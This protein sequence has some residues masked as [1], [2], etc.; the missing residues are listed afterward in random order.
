MLRFIFS[1]SVISLG[2]V[3]FCQEKEKGNTK[4]RRSF[5]P[6]ELKIGVNAI[7][8]GRSLI[9]SDFFMTHEFQ[10]TLSMYKTILVFDFGVEE[11]R[12][13]DTY[14]YTNKGSYFRI[15]ADW[16]FVK[17]HQTGNVLSLGLRYAE[18]RFDDDITYTT[19]Q[20]FGEQNYSFLNS[21]LLA[22]WA[23]LTVNLRGQVVSNLYMGFT[24]R[25][26]FSRKIN[27]ETILK[28]FDIP[29]F[30]KTKRQNST[31]FDYYIAWRIPL[32]KLE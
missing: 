10:G 20:G 27:R 13:G 8:S 26:Q 23:E 29:G 32:K 28:S 2:G 5:S 21:G 12:R 4:D 16:N 19:N 14:S 31:G 1:L 7:R 6:Y 15:G 18:S 9:R 17:N 24:M 30:G 25:W 3:S 11:N 22:K